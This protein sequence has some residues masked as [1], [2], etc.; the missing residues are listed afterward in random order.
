MRLKLLSMIAALMAMASP[1]TAQVTNDTIYNPKVIFSGMPQKY[2]IA[3]I[4]VTGVDN[5]EDYI[6]IGYSGLSVGQRVEIPGDDIKMAAKQI[7]RA[8]V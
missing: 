2:E 3:G 7:G 1:A 4:K 8:H 5:Y 6:I